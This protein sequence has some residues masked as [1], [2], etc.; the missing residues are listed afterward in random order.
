MTNQSNTVLVIG[1]GVGGMKAAMEL[2]EAGRDVVLIDQEAAIG[3]LMT[4]LDRTFPTNNCDLCTIS[5]DLSENA[6]EKHIEVLTLTRLT[7]VAGQA[8][9][10][11]A[12]LTHAPRY[13]DMEKCTACGDCYE[14]FPE[15]VRFSPGLDH[16]APTCMRYPQ[17]TPQAFSIDMEKCEDPEAL[18]NTCPAGAIFPEDTLRTEERKVGAIVLAIGAGLFDPGRLDN[19]GHGQY[20]DVV[21]GLEYERIMSASGPTGGELIRPSDGK[22]PRRLA[23]IQCVGSRGINREDVSYCSGVCCMYAIKEAI[24][25][26]ERFHD[27]IETTIFYMDMRT[28]GKDYELY[29]NLGTCA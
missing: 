9:D 8:G 5:P 3:G 4:R 27:D 18:A 29:Y 13:I 2:S 11:T 25:T 17:A 7:G 19:F 16:R 28:Y 23:W 15:C 1:G 10:F 12:T 21:T 24:V 14:A 26:K 6:R 22:Q 20:P